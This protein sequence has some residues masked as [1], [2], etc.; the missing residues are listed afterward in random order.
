MKIKIKYL[1][2]NTAHF[3]MRIKEEQY[4]KGKEAEENRFSEFK[5]EY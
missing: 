5:N 2:Q 1:Q 3:N 4:I